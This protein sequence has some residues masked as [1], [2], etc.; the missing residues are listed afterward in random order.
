M[1]TC[2]LGENSIQSHPRRLHIQHVSNN[3][4]KRAIQTILTMSGNENLRTKVEAAEVVVDRAQAAE[5][6]DRADEVAAADL[7]PTTIWRAKART[8]DVKRPES[9]TQKA[10]IRGR[11]RKRRKRRR[12][13]RKSE[14]ERRFATDLE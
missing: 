10:G 6:G 8:R 13:R 1:R 3:N 9:A 5:A 14:I 2:R 4:G 11:A 7:T 12:T